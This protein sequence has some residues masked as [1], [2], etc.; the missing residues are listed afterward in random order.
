VCANDIVAADMIASLG[1]LGI[2]VPDDLALIGFSN[3]Q[4]ALLNALGLTTMSQPY[5]Q[6]GRE[7]MALL[8]DRHARWLQRIPVRE[9]RLPMRLVV[10]SSCGA[11]RKN[12]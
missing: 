4:P 8:L 10:R 11:N 3:S 7:A 1:V 2:K 6:M 9:V 12:G 5:E